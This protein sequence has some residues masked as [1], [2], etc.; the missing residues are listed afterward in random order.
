S[1]DGGI[2]FNIQELCTAVQ[3]Q[4]PL[5]T[6]IFNDHRYTNVQ[7]QQKE[8]FDGRVI[9]SDLHNPDFVK[10]AESFGAA[11]F[12][13]DNPESLRGALREA[14][15]QRGPSIIEVKVTEFFPPPWPFLMMPQN[16]KQVC[17]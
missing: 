6:I 4:L 15:E 16:R 3:Y 8:W 7:R 9:C 1:G 13:A 2:M 12:L 17:Q 10:L 5:V 14:F 11:G